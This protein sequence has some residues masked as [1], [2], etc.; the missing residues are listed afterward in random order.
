M[1][2]ILPTPSPPQQPPLPRVYTP[3]GA[4]LS[5]TLYVTSPR[6]NISDHPTPSKNSI[7]S[8]LQILTLR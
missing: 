6:K 1:P 2:N 8:T 4:T 7:V 3:E 5:K